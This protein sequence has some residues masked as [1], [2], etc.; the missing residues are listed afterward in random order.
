LWSRDLEILLQT[1]K[2]AEAGEKDA[3]NKS[4]VENQNHRPSFPSSGRSHLFPFTNADAMQAK[5]K[6]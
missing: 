2:N 4:Q 1:G 6:Y 3:N 5:R